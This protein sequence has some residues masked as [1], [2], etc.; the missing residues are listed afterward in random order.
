MTISLIVAIAEN[1]VIGR[2]GG[3]PWRLPDDL[4]RFKALTMGHPMLMGRK[5]WESLGARPLPG[6]RHLVLTRQAGYRATGAEVV[7]TVDEALALLGDGDDEL[8][9]IGGAELYRLCLPRASR[10]YLTRVHA[11]PAGDTSLPDL[12]LGAWRLISQEYHPAD[13]RHPLA[14][15]F[16]HY[17]R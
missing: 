13:E 9:V 8:F 2:D 6:R 5:T 11:S 14:F 7:H 10:L 4:K 17:D 12:E 15:S 16:C 3:L 1:G